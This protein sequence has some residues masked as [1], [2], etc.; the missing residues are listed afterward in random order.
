M[1]LQNPSLRTPNLPAGQMVNEDGTPTPEEL[2][3]RQ[4][5][6][7]SLQNNFGPEGVVVPT[8]DSTNIAII[9]NNRVPNPSGG[10]SIP[11]CQFGTMLYNV[12]TNS[13]MIAIDDGAGNP[14]FKTVTL[15]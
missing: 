9:Q 11:T 8:Q 5:L 13:I 1:A 15:T 4:R 2:L 14:I 6:V 10:A 3:F 12:T 7:S